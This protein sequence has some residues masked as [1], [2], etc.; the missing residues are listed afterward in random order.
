MYLVLQQ[1]KEGEVKRLHDDH[2]RLLT[3]I[4]QRHEIEL[5]EARDAMKHAQVGTFV[6][7]G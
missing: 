7:L 5:I 6:S 3:E 4:R 2:E 1:E